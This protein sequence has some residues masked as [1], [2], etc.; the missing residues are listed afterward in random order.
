MCAYK[1]SIH[2]PRNVR[3]TDVRTYVLN[4]AWRVWVRSDCNL[5]CGQSTHV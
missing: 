5:F 4:Y 3:A 1:R 2:V